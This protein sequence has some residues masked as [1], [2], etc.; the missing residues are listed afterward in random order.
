M[1][2][3]FLRIQKN[4]LI[5]LKLYL[6]RYVST[7]PIF[8]FNSGSFDLNFINSYLIPYLISDK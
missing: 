8:G 6:E 7:L 3:Q 2:T 4:L 1:T 5:D